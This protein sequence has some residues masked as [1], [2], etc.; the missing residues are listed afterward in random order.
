MCP[1]QGTASD[2]ESRDRPPRSSAPPNRSYTLWGSPDANQQEESN[3][4]APGPVARRHFALDPVSRIGHGRGRLQWQFGKQGR[5]LRG[6]H[7]RR[8][9]ERSDHAQRAQLRQ[10]SGLHLEP[11]LRPSRRPQPGDRRQHH[12]HRAAGAD[13]TL[14]AGDAPDR[15][16]LQRQSGLGFRRHQHQPDKSQQRQSD[17]Q[18]QRVADERGRRHPGDPV[19]HRLLRPGQRPAYLQL[20]PVAGQP[21]GH[22][23][24]RQYRHG[25]VHRAGRDADALRL[26]VMFVA[27]PEK[28][29]E[30]SDSGLDGSDCWLFLFWQIAQQWRTA[31]VGA[32]AAIDRA[33]LTADDRAHAA[34][35]A[36]HDPARDIGH[37]GPQAVQHRDLRD[38]GAGRT[39][40]TRI[41]RGRK[42]SPRR[43]QRSWRRRR[44][45]R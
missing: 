25:N 39:I 20:D 12:L 36:R 38:D 4:P 2:M 42:R 6:Q 41:R 18:R 1:R 37:R 27:P 24:G 28:E 44:S 43:T 10:G 14:R 32:S 9:R 8:E 31:A 35:D 22:A 7:Q 21:G 26:Y 11:R 23:G 33:V 29:V 19:E 40:C 45:N 13:R 17:R 30:W 34:Q 5:H 3:W 15:D 16:R